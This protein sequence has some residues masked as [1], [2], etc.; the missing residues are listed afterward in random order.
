MQH[1]GELSPVTLTAKLVYAA[2]TIFEKGKNNGS[3]VRKYEEEKF[4]LALNSF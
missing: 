1:R 2:V 3:S 4:P